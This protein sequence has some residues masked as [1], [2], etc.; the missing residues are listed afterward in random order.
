MLEKLRVEA[1]EFRVRAEEIRARTEE[2]SAQMGQEGIGGGDE[3]SAMT[4]PPEQ[5]PGS[6]FGVSCDGEEDPAGFHDNDEQVRIA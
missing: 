1:D 5:A 2:L 3:L 6:G 4:A